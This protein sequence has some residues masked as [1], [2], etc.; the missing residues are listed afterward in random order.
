MEC[1][2]V[3][4]FD[5][6]LYHACCPDGI[7]AAWCV[8]RENKFK[9]RDFFI[10]GVRYN[11]PYPLDLIRNRKVVIVDFSYD[12][13]T[14]RE[15]CTVAKYVMILD[16]HDTAQ[17]DLQGLDE[18]I[19]NFSYIFDM[20][21]SGAQI[22]WD[23]CYL[24]NK[25]PWF[26]E[27]IADRDLWKWE[28]PN[29]KEIGKAMYHFG[30]YTFEKLEEL[31]R[32]EDENLRSEKSVRDAIIEHQKRVF[33][34]EGRTLLLLE[35]KDISFAVSKSVLCNFEGYRVRLASCSALIRSEVG[36]LLCDMRDCDFAATWR[37]D[38]ATD[39]W[40]ISL[41][42]S[43]D[44]GISL[45]KICERFGG[46][47]HQRACGF[48]IHGSRSQEWENASPEILLKMAYGNLHNYFKI[49]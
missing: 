21:R 41:R 2:K 23:W 24:D 30:W 28:Y 11:E 42:A 1:P 39:Q 45:N 9:N 10:R 47:G 46:G 3:T 43:K 19:S 26:I 17:R 48:T 31:Y 25:R 22:T 8:Y 15:M 14:I 40:W 37:Y 32:L 13:E 5:V 29:S 38:F 34:E 35:K 44:C 12:R 18:E 20:E 27:V 33:I 36:S 6:C 16:H 4:D 7:G 49:V